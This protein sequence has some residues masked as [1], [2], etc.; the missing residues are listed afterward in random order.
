[1]I[2]RGTHIVLGDAAAARPGLVGGISEVL[3]MPVGGRL[4]LIPLSGSGSGLR[5]DFVG[6][7]VRNEIFV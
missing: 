1:M 4:L 5:M 3:K 2:R 7:I 6:H